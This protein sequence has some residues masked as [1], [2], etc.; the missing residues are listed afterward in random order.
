MSPEKRKQLED[1]IE[2]RILH[3]YSKEEVRDWLLKECAVK[4]EQAGDLL[5]KAF[6]KRKRAARTWALLVLLFSVAGAIL[7]ISLIVRFLT[8]KGETDT[9]PGQ[10]RVLLFGIA[11]LCLG[12]TGLASCLP[13]LMKKESSKTSD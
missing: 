5:Q 7:G 9:D 10:I 11:F 1:R 8:T 6:G 13:K 3:G 2:S 12:A 4:E